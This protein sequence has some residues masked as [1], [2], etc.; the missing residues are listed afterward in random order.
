MPL[1]T[2]HRSDCEAVSRALDCRTMMECPSSTRFTRASA[3]G[4][5]RLSED[6]WNSHNPEEVSFN[7]S[8]GTYLR[9]GA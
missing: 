9:G 8:E 1:L 3:T 5:L 2:L 6:T 4:K 7:F